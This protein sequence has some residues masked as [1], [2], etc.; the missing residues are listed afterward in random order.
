MYPAGSSRETSCEMRNCEKEKEITLLSL[1]QNGLSL[2]RCPLNLS[3]GIFAL[4][5]K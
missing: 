2:N 1:T 5:S 3:P 4:L